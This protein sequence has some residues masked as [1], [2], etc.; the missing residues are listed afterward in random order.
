[1]FKPKDIKKIFGTNL[2][3]ERARI[4]FTQEYLAEL[5]DVSQE[6]V[7]RLESEKSNPSL[8]VAINLAAALGVTL[9]TLVPPELYLN[10]K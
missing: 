9:D 8:T 10:K 6:Y 7:A 3:V 2:R 1:M 5:A 4:H